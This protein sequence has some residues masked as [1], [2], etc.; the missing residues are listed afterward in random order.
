MRE[1]LTY[2]RHDRVLLL[3]VIAMSVVFVA[4][5]NFQVM[6][7]LL[8]FDAAGFRL[9]APVLELLQQRFIADVG[10]APDF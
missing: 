9:G 1:T 3:T 8:A 10:R 5:Y 6:V 7:P 2:I 4:A